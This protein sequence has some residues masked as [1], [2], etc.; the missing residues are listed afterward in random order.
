MG[1]EQPLIQDLEEKEPPVAG[2]SCSDGC[3]NGN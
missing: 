3:R 2:H 1:Y